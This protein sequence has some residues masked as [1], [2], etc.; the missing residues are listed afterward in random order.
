MA[1]C[2]GRASCITSLTLDAGRPSR[3]MVVVLSMLTEVA[4]TSD[5]CSPSTDTSTAKALAGN[6][7][8]TLMASR[9]R[10]EPKSID[11]STG[12]ASSNLLAQYEASFKSTAASAP[13]AQASADEVAVA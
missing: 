13:C 11:S 8:E 10:S 9:R 7:H 2:K 5:Q 3:S 6:S 4:N 1:P 12:P